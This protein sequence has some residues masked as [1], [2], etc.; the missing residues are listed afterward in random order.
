VLNLPGPLAGLG[1]KPIHYVCRHLTRL[2]HRCSS[3]ISDSID[4]YCSKHTKRTAHSSA[5]QLIQSPS[6]HDIDK[7]AKIAAGVQAA[8]AAAAAHLSGHLTV[9]E[10][11]GG[12]RAIPPTCYTSPYPTLPVRYATYI[13]NIRCAPDM[14]KVA[15]PAQNLRAVKLVQRGE[16]S[17]KLLLSP[18]TDV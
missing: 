5:R 2:L 9:P 13:Y 14:E 12:C 1:S 7:H 6:N 8:A 17:Y 15:A 4:T 3:A 10:T 16:G 18:V 11:G